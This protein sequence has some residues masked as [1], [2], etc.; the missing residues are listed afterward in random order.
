MPLRCN[1]RNQETERDALITWTAKSTTKLS[2]TVRCNVGIIFGVT[3]L[4]TKAAGP[5]S[6][7]VFLFCSINCVDGVMGV[8]ELGHRISEEY[9]NNG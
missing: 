5:R 6:V 1:I 8:E 2:A 9:E 7:I 3:H 4:S